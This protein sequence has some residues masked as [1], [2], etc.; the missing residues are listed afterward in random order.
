M[1]GET[2]LRIA[3][4]MAALAVAPGCQS[5]GLDEGG[6]GADST[7]SAQVV[8]IG[9]EQ[10]GSYLVVVTSPAPLLDGGPASFE[11]TITDGEGNQVQDLTIT[12]LIT[13]QAGSGPDAAILEETMGICSGCGAYRVNMESIAAGQYSLGFDVQAPDGGELTP[14]EF[15]FDVR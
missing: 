1:L 2:M 9:E 11:V 4:I 15:T 14:L 3:L 12:L 5:A 7:T 10:V 6:S 13:Q 8:S